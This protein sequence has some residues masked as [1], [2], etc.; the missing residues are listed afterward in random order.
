MRHTRSILGLA[1]SLCIAGGF[2][3]CNGNGEQSGNTAPAAPSTPVT[4]ITPITPVAEVTGKWTTGDLHVHTTESNDAQ[5][6]L[7]TVLDQAFTA[8]NHRLD[9]LVEPPARVGSR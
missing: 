6:P 8:N 1:A 2:Y 7:T 5:S 9:G 4:P 3:G